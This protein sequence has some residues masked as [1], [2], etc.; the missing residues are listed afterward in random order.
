LKIIKRKYEINPTVGH[1]RKYVY[2]IYYLVSVTQYFIIV[3]LLV[4][5]LEVEIENQYH[6]ILLLMVT[7]IS[8]ILSA[9]I[10]AV[11]AF[12]L[13]SWI[14]YRGGYLIIAYTA[15]SILIGVNS[16]FIFLFMSLEME[17]KPTV[18]DPTMFYSN[19]QVTN[20][21][22]HQLQSYISF[23]SFIALWAAST[24]LLRRQRKK[25]GAIK[26]Y[27]VVS[28]PLVYYLGIVQLILSNT[29]MEH[30]ILSAMETYSFNVINSIL[31]RPVGGVLFGIAFWMVGRSVSDRRISD[32]MKLSAI[33]I[34]L[35][36]ISNQDAG[37]Y[38]LPYPPFG[39]ATIS[40]VGI[41][42]YLLFVGIYYTSISISIDTDLRKT[43]ESS[44][45]EEFRFVSKIGKSQMEREIENRVKVMTKRS[46]EL[47]EEDTGIE[48]ELEDSQ[49]AEYVKLVV[50]EKEKMLRRNQHAREGKTDNDSETV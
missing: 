27:I 14:R 17:G 1:F 15:A 38:L 43:I 50:K 12:R 45:E 5:L 39:L 34:M 20:F 23:M 26:F 16:V 30:H 22:I 44:V 28:L 46:A 29:L 3:L 2:V 21:D 37:L 35:L 41:S 48:T 13:V 6:T 11:L 25:W 10:S 7:V 9:S 24:L 18:I 19:Y 36:S 8:L 40:F 33:G 49:V 32:Y 42:S 4:T 31:T 47:L